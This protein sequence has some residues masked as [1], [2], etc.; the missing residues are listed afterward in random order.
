MKNNCGSEALQNASEPLV[1]CSF[2]L[3]PLDGLPHRPIQKS[4]Q[5]FTLSLCVFLDLILHTLRYPENYP[6][7]LLL[8]IFFDCAIHRF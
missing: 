2:F 7:H 3:I 8:L 4:C 1:L 6:I 5:G